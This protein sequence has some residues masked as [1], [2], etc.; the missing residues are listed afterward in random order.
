MPQKNPRGRL[1]LRLWLN[2]V[3][4]AAWIAEAMLSSANP[5]IF[6]P[7]YEKVI[8]FSCEIEKKSL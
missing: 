2:V 3:I 6:F 8:F 1:C 7:S 5:V 4:P